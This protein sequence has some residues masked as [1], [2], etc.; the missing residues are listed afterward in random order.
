MKLS[1]KIQILLLTIAILF[2]ILTVAD[3]YSKYL[4]SASSTSDISIARW[5]ILVNNQDIRNN[6]DVSQVITPIFL[7]NQHISNDIIA[8]TSQGY[9]DIIIDHSAADVSFNYEINISTNENSSVTDIIATG[10]SINGG[11]TIEL[12]PG[13]TISADVLNTTTV[14][15][16]NLRIYITWD[17]SET[18]NMDNEEDT[19]ATKSNNPAKLDTNLTFT[20]IAA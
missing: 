6:S 15:V 5:R 14:K 4:T 16:I 8:P 10:Y 2:C 7:S 1:K 13:E 9:F 11:E 12:E 3:T 18:N 19:E 20:Q 17:D